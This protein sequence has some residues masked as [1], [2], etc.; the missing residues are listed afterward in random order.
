MRSARGEWRAGVASNRKEGGRMFEKVGRG[1]SLVRSPRQRWRALPITLVLCAVGVLSVPTAVLAGTRGYSLK[2]KVPHVV[3][4]SA[5]Y[6][7]LLSG[8]AKKAVKLLAYLDYQRC[9]RSPRVEVQ[10]G[11][12]GITYTVWGRFRESVPAHSELPPGKSRAVDYVCAYLFGGP[13]A[14]HVL[15][16][17]HRV[18]HVR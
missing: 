4:N 2:V 13:A 3:E 18:F 16:R 1:C 8:H 7:V 17:A 11:A 14:G 15:A 10:H 6:T 12:P 5:T 9:G